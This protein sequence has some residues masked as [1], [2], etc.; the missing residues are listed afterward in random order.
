VRR[1]R[2]PQAPPD[3]H[4]AEPLRFAQVEDARILEQEADRFTVADGES[5]GTTSAAT[6]FGRYTLGEKRGRSSEE[7]SN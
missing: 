1:I 3:A 7:R 4:E 2:S 6:D 5:T